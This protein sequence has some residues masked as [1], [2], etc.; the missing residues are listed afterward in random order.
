MGY[1][2]PVP[3]EAAILYGSRQVEK[4]KGTAKVAGPK[5]IESIFP[6]TDNESPDPDEEREILQKRRQIEQDLYGKGNRFDQ[7]T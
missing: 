1:V 5:K 7:Q 2:P 6:V 3:N 4:P